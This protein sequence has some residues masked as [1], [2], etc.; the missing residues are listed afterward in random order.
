MKLYL[1]SQVHQAALHKYGGPD[2]LEEARH[3]RIEAKLARRVKRKKE[4]QELERKELQQK[5]RIME[6]IEK[7]RKQQQEQTTLHKKSVLDEK[8]GQYQDVYLVGDTEV[9][10]EEL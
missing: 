4:E 1:E 7:E 9:E 5:Q 10:V 2:Q 6:V 8:T 3:Q